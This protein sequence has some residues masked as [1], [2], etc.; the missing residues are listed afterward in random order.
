ML[1]SWCWSYEWT[2]TD[3]VCGY[4]AAVIWIWAAFCTRGLFNYSM[5]WEKKDPRGSSPSP[6]SVC[7]AEQETTPCIIH[8]VYSF[9]LALTYTHTHTDTLCIR[10]PKY[11]KQK[12]VKNRCNKQTHKCMSAKQ[13]NMTNRM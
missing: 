2:G 12:Q 9:S 4:K 5:W 13:A 11:E 6:L 10:M 7:L 1:F 8:Y 3:P